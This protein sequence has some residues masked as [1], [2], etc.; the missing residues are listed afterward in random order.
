MDDLKN[1]LREKLWRARKF[2]VDVK[3]APAHAMFLTV[4]WSAFRRGWSH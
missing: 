3:N 2:M 1:Y 4:A